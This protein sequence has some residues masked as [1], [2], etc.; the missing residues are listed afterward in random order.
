MDDMRLHIGDRVILRCAYSALPAG[1]AGVIIHV[2]ATEP[3]LYRVRFNA[4]A[5]E[6]PI[7]RHYVE[8]TTDSIDGRAPDAA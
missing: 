1:T 2:Y 3:N 7:F 4:S 6:L 5:H 8:I